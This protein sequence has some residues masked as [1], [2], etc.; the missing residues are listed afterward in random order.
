MVMIKTRSLFG[1]IVAIAIV[2]AATALSIDT[3]M[4]VYA[5][6][7][8]MPPVTQQQQNQT[9]EP[10]TPL[11]TDQTSQ[12]WM[13]TFD[14][15]NCDFVSIG[16][17][18]Y[19]VLEPGYQVILGG[20]EDGEELQ[21][22]MTVLNDTKVVNGIETRVVEEKETEGGNIVE[23]SRNYFAMCKPTNNAIYFGEDVDMYEDGKIVSHE[24]AWLAGQNGSK[25]GMIM[26][27][28]VEVGLKYYQEIAP[29]VAEDRAVIISVNDT[30]DTPAGTFKQVL[31][32]EE[33]NPLKPGEKENKFYA[34]GIG[35][36]Q[37]EAIKLV[38]YTKP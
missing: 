37:D 35:L 6:N 4:N 17:N 38:N 18:S 34:P 27:E 13:T 10:S 33:T 30:L 8:T 3:A 2:G 26:P 15:E 19:F 5:Q 28:K 36:I 14:L 23:V 24:G 32:T 16:E 22:V 31:K 21:L 12:G 11:S 7:T 20:Q 9:A 29:G 1:F 25:A